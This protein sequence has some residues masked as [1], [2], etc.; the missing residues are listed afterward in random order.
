[1]RVFVFLEVA[2]AEVE[3]IVAELAIELAALARAEVADLVAELI[4]S[5][6]SSAIEV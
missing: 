2:L 3:V 4:P 1:M 6:G 5:L